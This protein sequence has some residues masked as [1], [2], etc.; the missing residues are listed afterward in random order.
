MKNKP[1]LLI[2]LLCAISPCSYG[3]T[4]RPAFLKKGDKVAIVAPSYRL[5]DSLVAM[6]CDSLKAYGF[7]PVIGRHVNE[8]YPEGEDSFSFYA[9]KPEDRADDLTWALRD[10]S[11]KAVICARGGYG[12]IQTLQSMDLGDFSRNPKWIVGYSD[13]TAIHMACVKAGVMSIHGNMCSNIAQN[14]LQEEGNSAMLHL[15]E[16]NLP[17]YEFPA[18]GHNT[19]GKARGTLIGGNLITLM[20]LVG[21]SFDC[22]DGRDCILFV[23]EVGESMH[24]IDRIF[25]ILK[26]Q[27]KMDSVKG[28]VFGDFTDCGSEF[29]YESTEDM[30][31]RITAEFGIPVAFGFPSGH[32]TLNLPLIEG[33]SVTLT[34]TQ[35]GSRLE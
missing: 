1:L 35:E 22:M 24:A 32:G 6:A 4:V 8:R 34:V 19:C 14:G 5:D 9:G 26:L 30:L 17:A 16:G 31:S 23:E 25:N 29:A 15:L 21:S 7:I 3:R 18:S 28:I 20:S 12:A 33:A 11:I 10:T 13:I 2:T 27:G